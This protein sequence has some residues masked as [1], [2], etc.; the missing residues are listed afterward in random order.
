MAQGTRFN[1]LPCGL[2]LVILTLALVQARK[3]TV[4]LTVLFLLRPRTFS[5]RFCRTVVILVVVRILVVL[6]TLKP[7]ATVSET[8]TKLSSCLTLKN[9][10]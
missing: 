3:P 9:F 1:A 2:S 7:L 4:T 10:S 6:G 8:L 5:F